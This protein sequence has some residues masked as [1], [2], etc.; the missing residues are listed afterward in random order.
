[1]LWGK[2]DAVVLTQQSPVQR[3]HGLPL[4][5]LEFWLSS[6]ICLPGRGFSTVD[7]YAFGCY[8]D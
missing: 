6:W 8:L 4:L 5:T 1:M 2:K 3:N 7:F